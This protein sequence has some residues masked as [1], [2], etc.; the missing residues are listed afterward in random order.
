MKTLIVYYSRTGHNKQVAKELAEMI[1]ADVEEIVELKPKGFVM[2]G[3]QSMTK[4]KGEIGDVAHDPADY[5]LVVLVAPLWF[6]G[7]SPALR[8]YIEKYLKKIKSIACLSV[9]GN[10]MKNEPYIN[11]LEQEYSLSIQPRLM[12]TDSELQKG[13]YS[14]RLKSFALALKSDR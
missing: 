4:A 1:S 7:I 10:G 14:E 9:S 12:L 2:S 11:K 3:W 8:T 5:D 6:G 13:I